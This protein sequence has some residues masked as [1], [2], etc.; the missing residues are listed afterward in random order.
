MSAQWFYSRGGQRQGPVS[1][2]QFQ[3]MAAVGQLQPTDL[4]W[5][6]GM[7]QWV[8]ASS[9]K[10]LFVV[11]TTPTSP[12]SPP[13]LPRLPANQ[14]NAAGWK[15]PFTL[16]QCL[17]SWPVIVVLLLLCFP[18]GL[19]LIWTHPSWPRRSKMVWS[20]AW[21]MFAVAIGLS[22]RNEPSEHSTSQSSRLQPSSTPLPTAQSETA[23]FNVSLAQVM[24]DLMTDSG[25]PTP[26]IQGK[27]FVQVPTGA[28]SLAQATLDESY[29]PLIQDTHF[30]YK[31]V[32]LNDTSW[33]WFFSHIRIPA[34][35]AATSELYILAMYQ[36]GERTRF[37]MLKDNQRQLSTKRR[38]VDNG[39]VQISNEIATGLADAVS[40]EP[41]LKL[42]AK[43]GDRW[44]CHDDGKD[45][46]FEVADFFT[47]QGSTIAVVKKQGSAKG[48]NGPLHFSTTTWYCRGFGI[49][50][51]QTFV[52]SGDGR[53]DHSTVRSFQ[54]ALIRKPAKH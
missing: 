53:S 5:K 51:E 34:S 4:V 35:D 25:T 1:S 36:N 50:R 22:G 14:V 10:G 3:R 20:A 15:P 39:Y 21:L 19:Y 16:P 9:I 31:V 46:A 40:W 17:Y 13:P 43:K 8:T 24:F 54:Y 11:P 52:I 28:T 27:E 29:F 48:P 30:E 47:L 6:D 32:R 42:G 33:G 41:L 38:R 45:V 26:V 44:E 7:E 12:T 37:D 49:A 2:K 23:G 18:F